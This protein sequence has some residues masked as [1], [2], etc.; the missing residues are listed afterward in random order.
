MPPQMSKK[1]EIDP[2]LAIADEMIGEKRPEG[3]HWKTV[4]EVAEMRKTGIRAARYWLED[5][6][7]KG[8]ME[9]SVGRHRGLPLK[10]YRP[11]Q[12][13]YP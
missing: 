9:Y 2:W 13:V 1:S 5:R 10:F 8:T 3:P 4:A 6:V 11:K 7:K 12:E